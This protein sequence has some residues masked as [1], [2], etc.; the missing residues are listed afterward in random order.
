VGSSKAQSGNHVTNRNLDHLTVFVQRELDLSVE[1][2]DAAD[3]LMKARYVALPDRFQ[4][5][6]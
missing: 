6:A 3:R 4:R 1:D 2:V 5:N